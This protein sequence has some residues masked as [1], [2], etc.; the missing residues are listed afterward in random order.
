MPPPDHAQAEIQA[1]LEK[2]EQASET[3]R[4]LA[5]TCLQQFRKECQSAI[6]WQRTEGRDRVLLGEDPDVI[7]AEVELCVGEARKRLKGRL[8]KLLETAAAKGF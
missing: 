3:V 7:L 6:D 2:T 1:L 4:D 8:E 5:A